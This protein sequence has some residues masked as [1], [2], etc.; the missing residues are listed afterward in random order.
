MIG[1]IDQNLITYFNADFN[2][3]Y[4]KIFVCP[5]KY[6]NLAPLQ[7][8]TV[9]FGKSKMKT[10]SPGEDKEAQPDDGSNKKAKDCKKVTN[11]TYYSGVGNTV[12]A[13]LSEAQ[14]PYENFKSTMQEVFR[15]YCEFEG[16]TPK[17]PIGTLIVNQKSEKSLREKCASREISSSA[18]AK[19]EI[20]DVIRA[21]IVLNS[22]NNYEDR[23]VCNALTKGVRNGKVKIVE[24]RNYYEMH[25]D[26]CGGE[27]SQYI[28]LSSLFK[29]DQAITK[30]Q[31]I[32]ALESG[33]VKNSGYHAVHVIFQL[34]NGFYGELQIMGEKMVKIKELEDIIYK[35]SGNKPVDEKFAQ[36]QKAYDEYIRGNSDKDALLRDY[37]RKA[38]NAERLKELHKYPRCED[39]E[40]LPLPKKSF[41]PEIF[42]FNNLARIAREK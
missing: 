28:P 33:T 37:T 14:A 5:K 36:V 7:K 10:A 32:S 24:I 39:T 30:K 31:G 19:D 40:F 25:K 12:R 41:L 1:K 34:E 38:Y 21:R 11:P 4:A 18:R 42:D 15:D 6:N 26:Y 16:N 27:D 3:G 20:R 2:Q 8:D 23:K 13:V 9:S 35:I 17:D 29:L 22:D